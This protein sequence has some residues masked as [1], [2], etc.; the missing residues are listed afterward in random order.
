MVSTADLETF[1]NV[2]E[3]KQVINLVKYLYTNEILLGLDMINKMQI[4]QSFQFTLLEVVRVALEGHSHLIDMEK[5]L[6]ELEATMEANG[7]D[8]PWRSP[9]L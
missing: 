4:S 9:C 8:L 7:S 1:F 2:Y 6:A 3:G 5:R